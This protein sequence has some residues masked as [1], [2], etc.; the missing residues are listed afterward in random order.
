MIAP[1]NGWTK[2]T[3]LKVI[4]NRKFEGRALI[5]GC[6]CYLDEQGNKCAVGLF[7]PDGHPAAKEHQML[8]R[9]LLNKYKDL[10][11]IMPISIDYINL[12]QRSHDQPDKK[13][14]AKEKMIQWVEENIQG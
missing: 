12:F 9:S 11:N 6:C 7:I 1:I 8:A 10:E 3:I 2:E 13:N 14:S 5:E 4:K